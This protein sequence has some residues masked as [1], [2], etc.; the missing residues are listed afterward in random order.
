MYLHFTKK[1]YRTVFLPNSTKNNYYCSFKLSDIMRISKHNMSSIPFHEKS[2]SVILVSK[3]ER[4]GWPMPQRAW[5]K[6]E[7]CSTFFHFSYIICVF[8][9]YY[10][11]MCF[12]YWPLQ[13]YFNGYWNSMQNESSMLVSYIIKSN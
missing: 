5:A 13:I 11:T 10:F 8:F 12:L 4:R 1:G 2:K 7:V 6:F 3:I 9:V